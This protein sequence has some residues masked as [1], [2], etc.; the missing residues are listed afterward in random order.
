MADQTFSVNSGFYD[1]VSSDRTY[2]ADDMNRPYKRLVSNG[3]Y[4]T[5]QGT[6]STDL[7]VKAS[8]GMVINV[9]PGQGI[10][11]DKWLE[12]DSLIAITVPSNSS[13]SPRLD[14]VIV[15][16][17]KRLAGRVANIVYR[18]GTASNTP[19]APAINTVTDV[20]EYRVANVLVNPSVSTIYQSNIY[21]RRGSSECPWITSLIQQVDISVLFNQYQD[22]Y[23][24]YYQTSTEAFE[25][26][27]EQREHDWDAFIES[28]TEDLTVTTNVVSLRS[29]YTTAGT[30]NIIPVGI[31]SYNTATD[32][33]FVYIN[34]LLADSTKYTYLSGNQIRLAAPL[35]GGQLVNFVVLKS[36]IG[37]D[38]STISTLISQLNERISEISEDTDWV[39]LALENNAEAYLPSYAPAFRRIGKQV[40]LRGAI[41]N[42]SAQNTTIATLP[43]G[44]R[45]GTRHIYTT[46]SVQGNFAIPIVLNISHY[47]EIT[48]TAIGNSIISNAMIPLDT[49][50]CV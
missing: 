20:I 6:P 5:P 36:V 4:A 39:T 31:P 16:V 49:T 38:L 41:K 34:G 24:R 40:Y 10:F 48:I 1:A 30:T 21:D 25:D 26:Y 44:C 14:S 18:T 9:Q 35:P 8:S 32:I 11:G 50:F 17:D 29:S 2:Y 33:L 3:V 12:N 46:C 13:T 7:Q 42:F 37:G 22:A 15:Q 47:G 45:P 28:L 27:E 43:V 19:S 23:A